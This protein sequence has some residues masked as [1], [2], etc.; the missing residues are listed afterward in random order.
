MPFL[1]LLLLALFI[2]PWLGLLLFLPL[3]LALV[4]IPFG[5]ALRSFFWLFAGPSQL[6]KVFSNRNVR[7]NHALEHATAH[8]LEEGLGRPLPLSG[9][10]VED[11]FFIDGPLGPLG[12]TTV[13]A[14]AR[15]ALSRLEAGDRTLAQHGRC[16]TTIIVVNFLASVAFLLLLVATGQMSFLAILVALLV[17]NAIGPFLSPLVQRYLTTDASVAGMEILGVEVRSGSSRTLGVSL[18]FP[19]RL[20]VVT[21]QPG[22]AL[23]AQVV[24]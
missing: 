17:A 8:V 3:I 11:G 6:L 18:S 16:G 13:L 20:F 21:R 1:F 5:F 14:A 19:N 24:P 23:T 22:Q 12:P 2:A 15:E 10:A 7:R 9:Y 4:M